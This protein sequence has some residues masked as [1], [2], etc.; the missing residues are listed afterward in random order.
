MQQYGLK[1]YVRITIGN[2]SENKKL[3]AAL[4]KV[5]RN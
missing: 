1:N 3:I 5:T 4:K 2:K